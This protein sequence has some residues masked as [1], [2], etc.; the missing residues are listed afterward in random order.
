MVRF[1]KKLNDLFSSNL[2]SVRTLIVTDVTFNASIQRTIRP[3]LISQN[4]I[5]REGMIDILEQFCFEALL[6]FTETVYN[7]FKH[8]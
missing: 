3:S 2:L 4:K 6:M 8:F 7:I 1:L 5:T